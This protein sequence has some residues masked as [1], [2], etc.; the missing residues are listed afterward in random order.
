MR[1][2][3]IV[4]AYVTATPEFRDVVEAL[5][6]EVRQAESVAGAILDRLVEPAEREQAD[7]QR[8]DHFLTVNITNNGKTISTTDAAQRRRADHAGGRRVDR[9]A[10][11][12]LSPRLRRPARRPSR[13]SR[14]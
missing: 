11:S 7:V 10:R 12:G 5:A 9:G 8:V 2:D 14:A 6:A 13:R 3:P 4:V 1:F